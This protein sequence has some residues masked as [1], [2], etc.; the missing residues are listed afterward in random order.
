MN[1]SKKAMDSIKEIIELDVTE[2]GRKVA[3]QQLE[4]DLQAANEV[5]REAVSVAHNKHEDA[6]RQLGQVCIKLPDA[7]H[8]SINEVLSK[9]VTDPK[10]TYRIVVTNG[11]DKITLIKAFRNVHGC[12]L[13][14]AKSWMDGK[15]KLS[16][17]VF[18]MDIV[19]YDEAQKLKIKIIK[20][21]N[22]AAFNDAGFTFA[23]LPSDYKKNPFPSNGGKPYSE[24]DD[25]CK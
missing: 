8:H 10:I 22:F 20:D 19:N 6:C 3:D 11:G 1:L 15:H 25:E 23:I 17:G 21:C 5:Y 14:E 16:P 12:G 2:F 13:E 7:V 9:A 24:T 4:K 18:Y